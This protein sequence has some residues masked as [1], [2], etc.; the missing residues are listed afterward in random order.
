MLQFAFLYLVALV[1]L[2]VGVGAAVYLGK[3]PR[4]LSFLVRLLGALMHARD[5]T[6]E[7]APSESPC[8]E[9]AEAEPARAEPAASKSSKDARAVELPSS[10]PS[11]AEQASADDSP[12]PIDSQ[13][14]VEEATSRDEPA[15]PDMTSPTADA[16][17]ADAQGWTQATAH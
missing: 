15:Q 12:A 9:S 10:T 3:A 2:T 14:P 17:A 6:A 5:E 1:N 16:P 11:P 7:P 4:D 8:G 13:L